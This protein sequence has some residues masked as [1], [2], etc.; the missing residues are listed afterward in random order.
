MSSPS[1]ELRAALT[2]GPEAPTQHTFRAGRALVIW[3]ALAVLLALWGADHLEQDIAARATA[4]LEGLPARV[5]VS[6][7]DLSLVMDAGSPDDAEVTSAVSRLAT[8]AGIREIVVSIDGT[9]DGVIG[10]PAVTVP[11][12]PPPPAATT[13]SL[14]L[15]S[16]PMGPL[17]VARLDDGALVLE[18][19]V[20]D[21]AVVERVTGVAEL[22]YA[23]LLSIDLVVDEAL[24]PAPWE[25]SLP[26]LVSVL[27]ISGDATLIL[28]D[29]AVD[30]TASAIDERRREQLAGAITMALAGSA[31]LE[32]EIEVTGLRPPTFTATAFPDGTIDLAGEM[33]DA[34]IA[35][36]IVA[37][38][39]MAYGPGN[40]TSDISVSD[41]VGRT[42][43]PFRI[44]YIFHSLSAIPEWSLVIDDD[45]ISGNLRGGATFATA[46]ADLTDQLRALLDIAAGILLRNPGVGAIIE[47]H[48]D[49]RGT[50]AANQRLS[51]ARARSAAIYLEAI[52]I[53]PGRLQAIGYG[54]TRP[55][56]DN[57]TSEG[58]AENRRIEFVLAPTGTLG[59]P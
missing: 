25:R 47:G 7:R 48:T 41:D 3:L 42:F 9:D 24:S 52:G 19:A 17:V 58:R 31:E 20:S 57:S 23:P 6:G 15:P 35:A 14:A 44:P 29:G 13:P 22:I 21:A 43:S 49:S 30:V 37:A 45:A 54:E 27:P 32:A 16:L 50:R 18:G 38:A 59:E 53:D 1:A 55:I 39:E 10:T 56:A 33:P 34:E 4:A 36:R 5:E 40:V 51:E 11:P 28:S 26:L 46:S 12:P 8:V 2:G